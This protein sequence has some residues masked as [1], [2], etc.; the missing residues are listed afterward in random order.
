[1][2]YQMVAT[3]VT[4]N[5]L[6]G[7]SLV[8]DVFTCNPSNIC[9]A[10]QAYTISTDSVLAWFLWISRASCQQLS[11]K[12]AIIFQLTQRVARFLYNSRASCCKQLL[13]LRVVLRLY[14]CL[15]TRSNYL[16]GHQSA[17][18]ASCSFP[19]LCPIFN[20]LIRLPQQLQQNGPTSQKNDTD[21]AHYNF[22][23][24]QPI[25]IIF[26]MMLLIEC[27]IKRRF[28]IPPLLTNVSA[29]PGET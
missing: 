6:E 27:A 26:G 7:H 2:A 18:I 12:T 3:V 28:V 29:L 25:L 5:D 9:A 23:T 20:I 8:A 13:Y 10:F 21:V 4:L 14:S 11:Q 15:A 22:D 1:M 19:R 16:V 17:R 24:H